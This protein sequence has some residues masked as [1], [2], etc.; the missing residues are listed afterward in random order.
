MDT[1]FKVITDGTQEGEGVEIEVLVENEK[2]ASMNFDEGLITVEGSDVLIS[3]NEL[4]AMYE[5]YQYGLNNL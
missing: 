5:A 2:F 1:E 3:F 4:E